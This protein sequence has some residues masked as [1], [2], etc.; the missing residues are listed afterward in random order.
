MLKPA[1]V[2]NRPGD[3]R[4]I[5]ARN[6]LVSLH[7]QLVDAVKAAPRQQEKSYHFGI[8]SAQRPSTALGSIAQPSCGTHKGGI[9]LYGTRRE[10]VQQMR[11][12]EVSPSGSVS[13]F[14]STAATPHRSNARMYLPLL[15]FRVRG[16]LSATWSGRELWE[17]NRST[18]AQIS[19]EPPGLS[20]PTAPFCMETSYFFHD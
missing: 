11:F 4:A 13:V 9:V 8:Q 17:A 1:T 12:W 19:V 15:P 6:A 10:I 7:V 20:G 5:G 16:P 18:L 14:R 2:A 3:I